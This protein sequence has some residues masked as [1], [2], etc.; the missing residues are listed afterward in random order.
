MLTIGHISH[1]KA[2]HEHHWLH[3]LESKQNKC[4]NLLYTFTNCL[5][6]HKSFI[7]AVRNILIH[8][9]ISIFFGN[10]TC[11]HLAKTIVCAIYQM[12]Y[13]LTLLLATAA[14][15]YDYHFLFSTV[16]LTKLNCMSCFMNSHGIS[17]NT[18]QQCEESFCHTKTTLLACILKCIYKM[19]SKSVHRLS[20]IARSD[21][22]F[23]TV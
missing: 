11:C 22:N 14:Y 23:F 17:E 12:T 19:N 15:F 9:Q 5:S 16:L 1:I 21:C 13:S 18:H 7:I 4:F 20:N 6:V 8:W 3:W 2:L 10:H